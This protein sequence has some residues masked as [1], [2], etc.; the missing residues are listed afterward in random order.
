MPPS[1]TDSTATHRDL[2]ALMASP[3]VQEATYDAIFHNTLTGIAYVD[4]EGNF[5]RVNPTFAEML[6]YATRELVNFKRWT[7]LVHP[8]DVR[9]NL[10]ESKDVVSGAQDGYRILLRYLHKY[11]G[12]VYCSVQVSRVADRNRT[13]IHLVTLAQQ[14]HLPDR[15]IAVQRDPQ[16]NAILQPV[17]PITDFLRTNW[18]WITGVGVPAVLGF[19]SACGVAVQNYYRLEAQNETQA[20]EIRRLNDKLDAALTRK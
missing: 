20:A 2:R 15:N 13:F 18:K 10:E 19:L 1:P 3:E 17:V 16:G 4:A 11:G 6:G 14:L 12:F 8:E 5:I 9:A 7:E